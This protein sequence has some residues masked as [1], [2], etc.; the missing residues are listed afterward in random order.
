[1]LFKNFNVE[2][3]NFAVVENRK[4]RLAMWAPLPTCRTE[5]SNDFIFCL[6]CFSVYIPTAHESVLKIEEHRLSIVEGKE[7]IWVGNLGM[8]H[9]LCIAAIARVSLPWR[10][11]YK[12]RDFGSFSDEHEFLRK[13]VHLK[14]HVFFSKQ[15]VHCEN[16]KAHFKFF[17]LWLKK[18]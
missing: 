7:S 9:H 4:P 3:C 11:R 5:W 10:G 2:T 16:T 14:K 17:T 13:I 18:T 15:H 1:M 6:F 12:K 8:K